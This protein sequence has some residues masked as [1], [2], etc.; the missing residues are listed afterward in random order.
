MDNVM[1]FRPGHRLSASSAAAMPFILGIS[2]SRS[3]TSGRLL[4]NSSSNS[5]P[6]EA[7]ATTSN[8]SMPPSR[9]RSP[10]R[11]SV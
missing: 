6:L 2:I 4:S 3:T 11:N 9:V 10:L 7:S 5:R 1:I 8:P